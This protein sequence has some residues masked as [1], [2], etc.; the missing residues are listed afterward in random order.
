MIPPVS[1]GEKPGCL[2]AVLDIIAL[3][4]LMAALGP[5]PGFIAWCALQLHQIAHSL[6]QRRL[7]TR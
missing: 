3:G 4:L 7:G 6:L 2:P 1:T 5:L